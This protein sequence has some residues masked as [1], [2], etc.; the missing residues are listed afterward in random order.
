MALA[1]GA[2]TVPTRATA[3]GTWGGQK[4]TNHLPLCVA[5][6][7]KIGSVRGHTDEHIPARRTLDVLIFRRFLITYTGSPQCFGADDV[8]ARG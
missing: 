5:Q 8:A 1:D 6:I 4:R 3:R 7:G 2:Q